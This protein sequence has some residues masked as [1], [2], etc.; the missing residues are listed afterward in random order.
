MDETAPAD[1]YCFKPSLFGAPSEFRLTPGGLSWSVGRRSGVISYGAIECIRVSFRPSG[2]LARAYLTEIW[3]SSAPKLTISSQGAKSIVEK[4]DQPAP[5]RA[6]IEALH[7]NLGEAPN[8]ELLKGI[9]PHL[10]WPGLAVLAGVVAACVALIVRAVQGG[11]WTGALFILVFLV[12]FAWQ[13]GAYFRANRPGA[14]AADAP[15]ADLL[16]RV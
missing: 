16:P 15:P 3:S 1:S 2:L 12:L 8:A 5:Y 4:I 14:Y 13:I 6:F 7:R 10:Y 11:A 9:A